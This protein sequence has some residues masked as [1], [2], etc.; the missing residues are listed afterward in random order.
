VPGVHITNPLLISL[1]YEL[2]ARPGFEEFADNHPLHIDLI[3]LYGRDE[4]AER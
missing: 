1:I 3:K 2:S 4:Q